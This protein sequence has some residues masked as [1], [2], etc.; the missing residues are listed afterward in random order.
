MKHVQTLDE[1]IDELSRMREQ[2]GGAVPVYS[3]GGMSFL[4]QLRVWIGSVGKSGPPKA[5]SRQGAPCVLVGH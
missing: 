4:L 1:L 5:V 2:V 3:P